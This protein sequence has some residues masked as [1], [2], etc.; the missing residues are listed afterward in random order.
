M[1]SPLKYVNGMI[2]SPRETQDPLSAHRLTSSFDVIEGSSARRK[3]QNYTHT[4][5][6]TKIDR[7]LATDTNFYPAG[8]T[9]VASKY[10]SKNKTRTNFPQIMHKL[11]EQT[12]GSFLKEGPD[13]YIND[14]FV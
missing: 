1:R 3:Q 2:Q 12:Q 11:M 5:L 7:R 9:P 4:A 14:F 13:R 8:E 6:K 10:T